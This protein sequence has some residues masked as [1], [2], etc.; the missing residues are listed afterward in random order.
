MGGLLSIVPCSVAFR[1]STTEA[2]I[3]SLLISDCF[4]RRNDC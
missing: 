1:V 3:F 4:L 2:M